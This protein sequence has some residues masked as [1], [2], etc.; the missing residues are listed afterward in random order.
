MLEADLEGGGEHGEDLAPAEVQVEQRDVVLEAELGR[1][2]HQGLAPGAHL[3]LVHDEL[4]VGLHHGLQLDEQQD[5]GRHGQQ[6]GEECQ[7]VDKGVNK[8]SR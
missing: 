8:S 6:Q 3:G 2:L 1:G 5:E 7:P 4:A